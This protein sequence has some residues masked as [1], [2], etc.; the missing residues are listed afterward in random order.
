MN[1]D[2]RLNKDNKRKP[3]KDPYYEDEPDYAGYIVRER[4]TSLNQYRGVFTSKD[5]EAINRRPD[6]FE[7]TA[8]F[9]VS[10]ENNDKIQ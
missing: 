2:E 7:R 1:L 4:S 8:I 6:V 5:E 10:G 9:K 3:V